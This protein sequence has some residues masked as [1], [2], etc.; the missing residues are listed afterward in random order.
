MA[1]VVWNRHKA[2]YRNSCVGC[3][4]GGLAI[5]FNT[6]RQVWDSPPLTH[7]LRAHPHFRGSHGWDSSSE[8]CNGQDA[9]STNILI[10]TTWL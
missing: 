1:V 10:P 3:V 4:R 5:M 2:C 7:H 6:E 8:N 9:C